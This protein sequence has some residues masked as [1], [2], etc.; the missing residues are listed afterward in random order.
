MVTR[1]GGVF[2]YLY[3]DIGDIKMDE[4]LRF[5]KEDE[6]STVWN[7]YVDAKSYDG[8]VWNEEYPSKDILYEDFKNG[9][10]CVFV[11]KNKIIGA[12]SVEFDEE[13]KN[14]NCWKIQCDKTIGF[15]RVVIAKEFL[16]QGYG[17]KMVENLLR[18]FEQ[19]GWDAV[20]ILVSPK[21]HSAM[22]IYKKL[23]F[24]F[25]CIE[26]VYDEDFWL[27]EKDLRK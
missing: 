23:D 5:A 11:S 7:M 9:N 17:R 6:L 19:N 2:F 21:N 14:F 20:R 26:N 13:F 1:L 12:I 27:C 10:L 18:F 24:D 4:I 16:G 25:I 8:C 15:A 22:A 3:E